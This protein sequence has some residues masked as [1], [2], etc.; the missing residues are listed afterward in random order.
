MPTDRY[1]GIVVLGVPRSGTTLLRRLLDAHPH[2]VCPPETNLLS[3]CSRFLGEEQ[4]ALGLRI[5]V[6]SGLAFAGFAEEEVLARLR[7]WVFGFFRQIAASAGKRRW[8]EKTA[9]DIFHLNEIERL[10]GDSCQFVCLSRHGLDVVCSMKELA[11]E[12]DRYLPEVHSYLCRHSSPHEAMAHAWVD[13]NQRLLGLIAE[14][15]SQCL[16][17]RYEDLLE[18]PVRELT[19]LFDF[20][21]EPT[22]VG[23]LMETAFRGGTAVGLGDWKTYETTGFDRGRVGRSRDLPPDVVAR[24]ATVINPTMMLLGYDAVVAP[25]VPTAEEARRRYRAMKLVRQMQSQRNTSDSD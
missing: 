17:V 7:E 6:V 10:V 9:F 1:E 3:A 4:S 11:D 18:Q 2:I 5:G 22:D 16:M 23:K 21:D 12:M 14:R 19:R 25:P 8:A 20:L 13:A 24:I 15:P